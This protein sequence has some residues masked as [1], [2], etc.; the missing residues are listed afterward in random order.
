MPLSNGV[1]NGL[2]CNVP[3]FQ[4]DY[5]NTYLTRDSPSV[6]NTAVVGNTM[7]M[8]KTTSEM[9]EEQ[10]RSLTDK[11]TAAFQQDTSCSSRGND[12]H[13]LLVFWILLA[14]A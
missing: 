13:F 11:T 7:R 2:Q 10:A 6:R 12:S 3:K 5:C 8:C 9:M 14:L 4:C 1:P